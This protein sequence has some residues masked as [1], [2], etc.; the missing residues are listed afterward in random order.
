MSPRL[1]EI[2]SHLH[3]PLFIHP[4]TPPRAVREAYYS[5]FD[6]QV[7]LAF[8]AFGLGWHYDL[9]YSFFDLSLA[10]VLDR[11][12]DLQIILR[13]WGEVVLFYSERLK[14]FSRVKKLQVCSR[15]DA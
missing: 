9:E 8:A 1:G 3:I 2:A 4:Q 15:H 5:G 6:P 10:G 14:A 11:F 12:S 13:H 7:D